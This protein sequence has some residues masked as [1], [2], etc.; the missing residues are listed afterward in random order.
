MLFRSLR[1]FRKIR[2][3]DKPVMIIANTIK[4]KGISFMENALRWHHSVPDAR[5]L[6]LARK[7]LLNG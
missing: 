4:G 2:V 6:S 7:E 1:V 3:S 5:E